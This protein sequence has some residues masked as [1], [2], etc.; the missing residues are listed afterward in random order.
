M[1]INIVSQTVCFT[2]ECSPSSPF[3]VY[4]FSKMS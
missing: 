1:H 2:I 3:A 4:A